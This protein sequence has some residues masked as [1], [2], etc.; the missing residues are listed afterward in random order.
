MGFFA[1]AHLF[2]PPF[3]LSISLNFSDFVNTTVL[4]I[5][6]ILSSHLKF[7]ID[8]FLATEGDNADPPKRTNKTLNKGARGEKAGRTQP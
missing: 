4:P 5:I 2:M 8:R 3:F 1:F 6:L 7:H